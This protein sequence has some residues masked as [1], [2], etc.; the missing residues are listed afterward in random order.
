M[1]RI[2]SLIWRKQLTADD[3]TERKDS[4]VLEV[5]IDLIPG[6]AIP[7]GLRVNA[8]ISIPPP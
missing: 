2:G 8:Y 7:A 4:R 3:P 5:L 1:G 6:V